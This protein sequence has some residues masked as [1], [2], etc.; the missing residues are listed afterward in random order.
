MGP[1]PNRE[2]AV[3][4]VL[5]ALDAAT[6][7]I[8]QVDSTEHV[9]QLIVD[10]VRPLVGA[11]YAAIGTMDALGRLD[12][13][14]T[15]G[16]DDRTRRL[17]G[18]PPHGDG[19]L[20]MIVR[21][22][23]PVRVANI[24][25]HPESA[26]FPPHHPPMTTL[27]GVPVTIRGRSVGRL[28]LTDKDGGAEFTAFD[29]RLVTAFAHHA[30]IAIENA[31]IYEQLHGLT[32]ME[33]RERIGR[34]LH[35]GIIQQLYGIGL[36]LEDVPDLMDEDASEAALRVEG[37]IDA[38]HGSIRD[39]RAFV[40]G[41]RP[42]IVE[43]STLT[44]GIAALAD[45]FRHNTLI[46]PKLVLSE[47]ISDDD[48]LANEL[49]AVTSEALSNI[50]RHARASAVTVSLDIERGDIVLRISDDGIGLPEDGR[51]TAGHHGLTNMRERARRL[52]GRLEIDS[53]P[54]L[55]TAIA[56]RIPVVPTRAAEEAG[57]VP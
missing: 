15:S 20:G 10:R 45:A 39:L 14:V 38:L 5:D 33:E 6:R 50:A 13:F 25:A 4:E 8:A 37:A 3:V 43:G 46:T 7:A 41:L 34:D 28:Y 49:L 27:L 56:A 53:R 18:Q 52:G 22:Q 57:G 12:E 35:D 48:G 16:V 51:G 17:L 29:E 40:F 44:A 23:R 31:R 42:E 36:S 19:L 47:V 1:L 21:E 11:H 26:G 24:G 9:L 54:G 30:A 32:V 55:G 2:D